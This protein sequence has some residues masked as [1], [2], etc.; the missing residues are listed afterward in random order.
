MAWDPSLEVAFHPR[1]VAMVGMSASAKSGDTQ[2]LG[3]TSFITSYEQLGFQGRIYPVN[4]KATE[5]LGY[6]AYPDVSSIPEP[7]DLVIISVP[8]TAVPGVL[9]DCITA[10]A[11]NIHMYTSGFEATA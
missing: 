5:I 9:E 1:V 11:R 2:A 8:A 6:K 10:N 3:G 4:P 7:V